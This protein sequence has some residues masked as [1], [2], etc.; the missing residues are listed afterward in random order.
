[1][2]DIEHAGEGSQVAIPFTL[3]WKKDFYS[4]TNY[5]GVDRAYLALQNLDMIGTYTMTKVVG[6][7]GDS[8]TGYEGVTGWNKDTYP[9]IYFKYVAAG[10]LISI[11]PSD[12]DR[13]AGT[14]ALATINISTGQ[15]VTQANASGFGGS[16]DI[17]NI[18]FV[19]ND[20]WNVAFTA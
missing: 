13:S 16:V 1:M 9:T 10:T 14:N 8:I 6:L 3:T 18:S 4:F 2:G 5:S 12:A 19:G 17:V 15:T 11:Y 20:T 7:S